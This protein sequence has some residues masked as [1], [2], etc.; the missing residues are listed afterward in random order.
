MSEQKQY[1]VSDQ[2]KVLDGYDIYRSAKLIVA[3]VVVDGNSGRDMRMYRWQLRG[4]SWKVDL[5][6][7][8]VAG[9]KWDE[10]AAKAKEF[11]E[12]YEIHK[13]GKES[14]PKDQTEGQVSG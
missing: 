13:K 8:S 6:R 7:M 2:F 3:L 9:W 12:K 4:E 11:V 14:A 5:C 10:V 1:P